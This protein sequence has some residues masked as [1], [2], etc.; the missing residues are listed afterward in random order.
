MVE[1]DADLR[2]VFL[3][4][5]ARVTRDMKTRGLSIPPP[6]LRGGGWRRLAPG[7][8]SY[9]LMPEE[10]TM[11]LADLLNQ[12]R[13]S[14]EYK[15]CVEAVR[16]HPVLKNRVDTLV[17]AVFSAS[18]TEAEQVP[19]RVIWALQA[20][21]EPASSFDGA[22]NEVIRWL[23]RDQDEI[24]VGPVETIVPKRGGPRGRLIFIHAQDYGSGSRFRSL[25]GR[26]ARM[27]CR[28]FRRQPT[29]GAR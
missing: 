18:N 3:A 12:Q 26:T 24:A 20:I 13:E 16:A 9:A 17:G 29:G 5:V 14:D 11:K 10:P 6:E 7:L 19:E 15:A 4:Y 28:S 27:A 2:L 25:L 21:P 23:A 1:D 22:F 8:F